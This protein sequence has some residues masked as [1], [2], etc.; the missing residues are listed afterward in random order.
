[1]KLIFVFNT[2]NGIFN[3]SLDF[4][5]KMISPKTYPCALHLLIQGG[6]K[7]KAIWSKFI[8]ETNQK[9]V[10][11]NIDEFEE[12]FRTSYDYP[13]V[14]R[15]EEDQMRVIYSKEQLAKFKSTESFI[16]TIRSLST[17]EAL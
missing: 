6:K 10:F 16:E 12:Q 2:K 13:V 14:V 1:M 7:E 9:L 5:H 17:V 8:N 15:E 3:T 4:F 11:Y